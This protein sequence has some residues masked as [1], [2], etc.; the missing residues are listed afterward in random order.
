VLLQT[1]PN[2][3]QPQA[4]CCAAPDEVVA[5]VMLS[6]DSVEAVGTG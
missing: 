3:A 4:S 6:R 2:A 5:R 1:A